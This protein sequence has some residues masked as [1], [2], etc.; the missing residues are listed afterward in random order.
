MGD[1][2][3]ECTAGDPTR[4]FPQRFDFLAARWLPLRALVAGMFAL[5]VWLLGR[6]SLLGCFLWQWQLAFSDVAVE[7][8]RMNVHLS[9]VAARLA[10]STQQ[11]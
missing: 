6:E 1:G 3:F 9:H 2:G 7:R 11:R 8:C 10:T 5:E 4:A